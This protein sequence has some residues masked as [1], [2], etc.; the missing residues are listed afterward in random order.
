MLRIILLLTCLS[1]SPGFVFAGTVDSKTGPKAVL[2]ET[3]FEFEPVF[4]GTQVAHDFILYNKGDE[5][6]RILKVKSG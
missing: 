6:L 2:A 3:V 1:L 4:E 5:P